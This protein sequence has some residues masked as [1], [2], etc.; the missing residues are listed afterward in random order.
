MSTSLRRGRHRAEHCTI[1]PL[2]ELSRS[3]TGFARKGALVAAASGL[4]VSALVPSAHAADK[5]AARI[6]TVDVDALTAAARA[7][8]ATSPAVTVSAESTLTVETGT[9]AVTPAP[10]PEPVPEPAPRTTTTSRTTT[11]AATTTTTTRTAEAAAP[12]AAPAPA[13]APAPASDGSIGDRV[14]SVANGLTGIRYVSGG[15]TPASGL[16]CSGLVS[17][18]YAQVGIY[19]PHSSTSI[20]NVGRVISAAEARPGDLL[21]SPGHISIYMGGGMQVEAVYAGT[22]SR[23][24]R[25]WQ[26]NPVYLRVY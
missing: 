2:T 19:L 13:P 3:A 9:I 20:R 22:A 14:A 24:S 6:T 11:R 16:D 5:P 18:A 7:S 15:S 17:Y 25:I 26:D 4:L 10:K 21:W 12:A 1:T 8:L 23:Y